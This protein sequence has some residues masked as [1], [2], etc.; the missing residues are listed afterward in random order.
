MT[1]H[2][3]AESAMILGIF[4]GSGQV[5]RYRTADPAGHCFVS[6]SSWATTVSGI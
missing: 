1:E 5:E 4:R 2:T 3:V 6:S